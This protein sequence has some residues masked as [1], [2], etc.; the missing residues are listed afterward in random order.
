MFRPVKPYKIPHAEEL[1]SSHVNICS[2]R[3]HDFR[4]L[5]RGTEAEVFV[6]RDQLGGQDVVLKK[7][8]PGSPAST[9]ELEG[10]IRLSQQ[11]GDSGFLEAQD[12]I[13]EGGQLAGYTGRFIESGSLSEN[14]G[15]LDDASVLCALDD[16]CQAMG[17]LHSF[18][19]VHCDLKPDNI[20]TEHRDGAIRAY[21]TDLG[22]AVSRGAQYPTTVQGTREYM[23]PE[24]NAGQPLT[25]TADVYSFG[26]TLE[27]LAPYFGS[28]SL[29]ARATALGGHCAHPDPGQR[30]QSFWEIR[31][32]LR[33]IQS[34]ECGSALKESLSPPLRD[35]GVRLRVN[36]LRQRLC[37]DESS[38]RGMC[39]VTGDPGIGKSRLLREFC[40]DRQLAGEETVRLTD[41][42][43]PEE[44][45]QFLRHSLPEIARTAGP[46]RHHR[47]WISGE[48]QLDCAFSSDELRSL[49][50]M[51][52]DYGIVV[53]LEHRASNPDLGQNG[54]LQVRV[55][56]FSLREC[57]IA[58]SHLQDNPSLSVV[59][60]QALQ[61]ATGG[62][63][64]LVRLYLRARRAGA[65]TSRDD[66]PVNFDR[67]DHPT[68]SHWNQRYQK[69]PE[70][71]KTFLRRVSL[72]HDEVPVSLFMDAGT[73][74]DEVCRWASAL[75]ECGWIKRIDL[76]GNAPKYRYT[77]R[78][79]RNFVRLQ[80]TG[81]CLQEWGASLLAA[82]GQ[83][84]AAEALC[85]S[86]AWEIHRLARQPSGQPP[87]PELW[88]ARKSIADAKLATYA[89][90]KTYHRER[91]GD[92]EN[93]SA[94]ASD[95]SDGF[96]ELGSVRRQRRW[97]AIAFSRLRG[98]QSGAGMS[99]AAAHFLCRVHNLS[100]ELPAK[101]EALTVL[102]R[103]G[104]ISDG[105]VRG[106]FLS[107]LGTVHLMQSGFQT[108]NERYFEAHHLLEHAAPHSPEFVRNLNRLGLS[109]MRIGRYS[110]ARKYLEQCRKLSQ[111]FGFS[112]IGRL[113]LGNLVILE[114]ALG[115]PQ[116]AMRCSQRVLEG[117]RAAHEPL[118]YL[119]ALQDKVTCLVELGQCYAATRTAQL[120]VRLANLHSD[121]YEL[122][123]ALNNLGWVLTMQGEVGRSHEHLEAAIRLHL[124]TGDRL[125]AARTRLNM[126]WNYLTAD[127]PEKAESHC[128]SALEEIGR[129]NDLHGLCEALRILAQAAVMKDDLPAAEA[130]LNRIP[131]GE[132]LLSP[133]DRAETALAR[134]NLHL[135]MQQESDA[136]RLINELATNPI[137]TNVHPMR[138][139]FGRL[140]GFWH[141]LRGD[142]DAALATLG[143]ALSACRQAGRTDKLIDTLIVAALLA[144]RMRNRS[145]AQRYLRI[146]KKLID[147]MRGLLP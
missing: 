100:G 91:A 72:F 112:R 53:L 80:V 5:S 4:V 126:A 9:K 48:T 23:A 71:L 40:L 26:K 104:G 103:D 83:A 143:S 99:L 1:V 116:A 84:G 119:M 123:H 22:L 129:Q 49:H 60:G 32:S 27:R 59:S 15:K 65:S 10:V 19:L 52:V 117:Y 146:V 67:L 76:H 68:I 11:L 39:L 24:Q 92:G 120:A 64:S 135:W 94:M 42:V 34:D 113:A 106:Y 16:V 142:F 78:S 97:A 138:C 31:A 21:V 98:Q 122:R 44:M 144:G 43:S 47:L 107:E 145:V 73:S 66:E 85:P 62:N 2:Q 12:A 109:L 30:P 37:G 51:A 79:A 7:S 118:L 14:V 121:Q 147:F 86:D 128:Q 115:E 75:A 133:L 77:C 108:A 29:T 13:L 96:A 139:E 3:L 69:L 56:P 74:M 114:R 140:C 8:M 87:A 38:W 134:L 20:L 141:T 18:G 41:I 58:S 88:S 57:I 82:L 63:P 55:N 89:L 25:E 110:S 45:I 137:V 136:K 50:A 101:Q 124:R 132:S 95:I 111:Q 17:Y 36:N 81:A 125:W 90:L 130:S 70:I 102:L 6:A 131:E 61:L 105:H 33:Q 54:L 127:L 46:A 28:A 93:L 35:A